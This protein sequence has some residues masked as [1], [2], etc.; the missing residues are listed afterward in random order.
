[1]G[2]MA[3]YA[4]RYHKLVTQVGHTS[5]LKP[6]LQSTI[7]DE[8]FN[9]VS[10]R[11]TFDEGKQ[12]ELIHTV[13]TQ[14]DQLMTT[15]YEDHLME[16]VVA[17]RTMDTLCAY[18]DDLGKQIADGKPVADN[19]TVYDE[20]R[21]VSDL[22]VDMLVKYA[23]LEIQAATKTSNEIFRIVSLILF[24]L[25][26]LLV[27]TFVFSG[28]A[29]R[30][31][32]KNIR[33]PIHKLEQFAHELAEGNLERRIPTQDLEELKGLSASLNTMASK[34]EDLIE[35][36]TQ[37][38]ENLKKSELRTLQA[39]IAP[40]FLYNTL[41]AIVWLAEAHKTDEVIHITRSISD[42]FRI[43]LSQGLDWIPI[44]EEV[45]HLTGYLQIQKI[46][47]RD[48]LEYEVDIP[49]NLYDYQMLKLLL[50]P[51]VENAIYHGIK[52]R[53]IG[54]KVTVLGR[55]EEGHLL[56]SVSDTGI[57]MTEER[58]DFIKQ[59]LYE[60]QRDSSL[61]FGLYNV[62]QRIRLYYNQ[63]NGI[64]MEST[65]SGTTISFRVPVRS[66]SYE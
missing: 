28:L 8:I 10:G 57:G 4:S 54:G 30:S 37:E 44:S 40:H 12:Y 34:L 15:A 25:A 21:S 51:L 17:R 58:V 39:Q 20:V 2:M 13:N 19:E 22:V 11:I 60:K 49:Q 55:K 33:A 36:N 59:S 27:L 48:I 24:L 3:N 61:G 41:D 56:F 7:P 5:E 65:S 45:R 50:Q 1:L 26:L 32:A 46:R 47:Y 63:P 53:R 42:F 66:G 35:A 6:Y 14:L 38:Q 23:D 62:D 64:E 18:V 43:S 31:L 52:H 16:L 9:I 29:Q